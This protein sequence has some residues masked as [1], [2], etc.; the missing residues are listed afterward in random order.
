[1]HAALRDDL[2]GD[3]AG[4][5]SA[6]S[7]PRRNKYLVAGAAMIGAG[8]MAVTP[9]VPAVPDI[10]KR[11]IELS[12][13]ANPLTV[14][15]E[16]LEE[17]ATNLQLLGINS[18]NASQAFF[19]ALAASDVSDEIVDLI[20]ANVTDPL[21]FFNALVAYQTNYGEAFNNAFF[22]A[23]DP[24]TT[25]NEAGA[26][27]RL[28]VAF[29]KLFA[30]TLNNI[31]T[32][33]PAGQ[34]GPFTQAVFEANNWFVIDLLGALRPLTPLNSLPSQFVAGLPGAGDTLPK[35]LDAL[36]EA[37]LI[38]AAVGPGQTAAFQVAAVL[39]DT[40]AAI[41]A[42]DIQT[43]LN[44]LANLPVRTVNA[45]VNGFAP[46]FSPGGAEWPSLID[47]TQQ[48]VGL[49]KYLTVDFPRQLTTILGGTLPPVV[50]TPPAGAT[51][52][53]ELTKVASTE[54]T[55]GSDTVTLKVEAAPGTSAP[56]NEVDDTATAD[57]ALGQAAAV[58]AKTEPVEGA[59]KPE[60]VAKKVR[61]QAGANALKGIS[62]GVSKAVKDASDNFKNAVT[63]GRHA[64]GAEAANASDSTPKH[65]KPDNESDKGADDSSDKGAE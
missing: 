2:S 38:R 60:P 36:S 9:M 11:A 64:S 3:E 31:V 65:A 27:A 19:A 18:S 15:Q 16:S 56:A 33:D 44:E 32:Y 54:V 7:A 17:T 48:Q 46:S 22:R 40:L 12:A 23:D 13:A 57:S 6:Q 61:S 10:E 35:L 59:A 21:G 51:A 42:G 25:A 53:S 5:E 29:E 1:V 50:T 52:A 58:E 20:T 63:G 49:I 41:E 55:P 28:Q 37:A 34:Q 47:P 8:A 26:L 24:A 30:T 14:L 39:D 43:A 45:F 4:F 62:D